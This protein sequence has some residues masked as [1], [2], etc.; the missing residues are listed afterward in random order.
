MLQKLGGWK[1]EV[2]VSPRNSVHY[3]PTE[4]IKSLVRVNGRGGS[5]RSVFEHKSFFAEQKNKKKIQQQQI[6]K[7]FNT[8]SLSTTIQP[9][10]QSNYSTHTTTTLWYTPVHQQNHLFNT[11][12]ILQQIHFH[13]DNFHKFLHILQVLSQVSQQS[14]MSFTYAH[15]ILFKYLLYLCV[16]L[17]IFCLVLSWYQKN[18]TFSKKKK[19][20]H[21]NICRLWFF[22]R[23]I[24]FL[25]FFFLFSFFFFFF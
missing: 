21:S 11:K 2:S 16:Y 23:L 17:F 12:L 7:Q 18:N 15:S 9:T 24:F 3:A 22:F 4:S 8:R 13:Q 1:I 25:V 20:N 5:I 19:K 6:I 14:S 10:T